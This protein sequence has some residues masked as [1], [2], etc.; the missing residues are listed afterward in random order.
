[1]PARDFFSRILNEILVFLDSEV[2]SAM[3]LSRSPDASYSYVRQL[4][5]KGEIDR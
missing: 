5:A 1:M 4:L 3:G 2:V